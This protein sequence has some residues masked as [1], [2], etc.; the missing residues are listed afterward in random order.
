MQNGVEKSEDWKTLRVV[1]SDYAFLE[2]RAK[3]QNLSIAACLHQ[4]IRRER[5]IGAMRSMIE[6]LAEQV[7][8]MER[9]AQNSASDI[10][11]RLRR[12]EA[13]RSVKANRERA[14]AVA[15]D[16]IPFEDHDRYGLLT[17]LTHVRDLA[18]HL[19][20]ELAATTAERAE[21]AMNELYGVASS[22]ASETPE[23]PTADDERHGRER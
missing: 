10:T 21:A 4:T 8:V 23:E 11:T 13:D 2:Q 14:Q 20:P 22:E 19:V 16:G 7:R 1:E 5:S 6:S 17:V 15:P 9:F 18:E 3:D 12:I